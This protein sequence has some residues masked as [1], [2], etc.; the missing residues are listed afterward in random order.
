MLGPTLNPVEQYIWAYAEYLIRAGIPSVRVRR[1]DPLPELDGQPI[2]S[3]DRFRNGLRG[4]AKL[5]PEPPY[6]PTRAG[7]LDLGFMWQEDGQWYDFHHRI[8]L[9]FGSTDDGESYIELRLEL[10]SREA[11]H[12]PSHYI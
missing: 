12:P 2:P 4:W 1:S 10:I 7:T 8:H 6:Q 3:F 11:A 9:S 5:E